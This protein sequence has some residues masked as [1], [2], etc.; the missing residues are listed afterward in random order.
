M[1]HKLLVY[2]G[3]HSLS[4]TTGNRHIPRLFRIPSSLYQIV[5]EAAM[6]DQQ[7]KSKFIPLTDP[8]NNYISPLSPDP[9]TVKSNNII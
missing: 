1:I 3:R 7:R 9:Y 2:K 8:S 5:A 4:V 6:L